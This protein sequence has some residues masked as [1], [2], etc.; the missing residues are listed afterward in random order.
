MALDGDARGP[1][2][3]KQFKQLQLP[4]RLVLTGA[5]VS[6]QFLQ[7]TCG[8][9][10]GAIVNSFLATAWTFLPKTNPVRKEAAL[11][12][13]ILKRPVS[14]FDGDAAGALWAYKAAIERGGATA[15]RHQRRARDEAARARD[16]G[17][18]DL[19]L[20]NEP[21]GPPARLD[22]GREDPELPGQAALRPGLHE[23]EVAMRAPQTLVARRLRRS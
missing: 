20:A 17:G 22:V 1:T 9:V 5:N 8:D 16:A 11:L 14:N 12:R 23:E 6:P 19:P 7:G 10:N 3:V 13:S 4:Q 2:I 15:S 18:Q 21:P